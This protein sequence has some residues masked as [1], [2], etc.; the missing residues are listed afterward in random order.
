MKQTF[1]PLALCL[2]AACSTPA[3]EESASPQASTE[4]IAT[5][6]ARPVIASLTIDE[7]ESR[8]QH[9]KD[10]AMAS[11]FNRIV[12]SFKVGGESITGFE[13]R[14]F[15][16]GTILDGDSR[17]GYTPEQ[18]RFIDK[19]FEAKDKVNELVEEFLSRNYAGPQP[20]AGTKA[21]SEW[22]PRNLLKC[23]D[24]YHSKALDDLMQKYVQDPDKI[25]GER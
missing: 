24:L 15:F 4:A 13:R 9:F 21:A 3:P 22:S 16:E 14:A 12:K 19:W 7:N 6:T 2:I 25:A 20:R 23:F 1:M 5:E 18:E 11:C 17:D 10:Y 8:G